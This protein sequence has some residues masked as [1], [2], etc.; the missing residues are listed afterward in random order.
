MRIIEAFEIK[1]EIEE[2]SKT[3]EDLAKSLDVPGKR[4]EIKKLEAK[5][6]QA[7]FWDDSEKATAIV[8][9]LNGQKDTVDLYDRLKKGWTISLKCWRFYQTKS[10][11]TI[12]K[13][14]KATCLNIRKKLK[15]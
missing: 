11:R 8:V 15:N 13:I 14:L 10:I 7:D 4:D 12:K 6:L 9:D 1:N 2:L 3:L 5:T